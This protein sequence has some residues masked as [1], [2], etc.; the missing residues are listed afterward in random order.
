MMMKYVLKG[1]M[2]LFITLGSVSI[3]YAQNITVH[4]TVMAADDGSPL[5]GATVLMGNIH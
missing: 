2:A 4:G 1:L 3:L 5:P